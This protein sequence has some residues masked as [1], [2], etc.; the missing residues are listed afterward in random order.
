M[1]ARFVFFN[2]TQKRKIIKEN[3]S[4]FLELILEDLIIDAK[5][6]LGGEFVKTFGELVGKISPGFELSP[7]I[8]F[9]ELF[10]EASLE[11]E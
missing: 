6:D 7:V 11:L 4:K 9:L 5:L 10:Q 3:N 8:G 1:E 2:L